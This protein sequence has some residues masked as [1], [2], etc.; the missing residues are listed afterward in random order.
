[1]AFQRPHSWIGRHWVA[2]QLPKEPLSHDRAERIF[3]VKCWSRVTPIKKK[4]ED[5]TYQIGQF[6]VL[7]LKGGIWIAVV[8]FYNGVHPQKVGH[9][10]GIFHRVGVVL[11]MAILREK[12][13]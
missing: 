2:G 10:I 7:Q 13:I 6:V 5:S 11:P 8:F 12:S 4:N 9:A 1:M 3:I